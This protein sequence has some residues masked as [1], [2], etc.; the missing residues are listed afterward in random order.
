MS[1]LA[2]SL[3]G[4]V[5]GGKKFY[6]QLLQMQDVLFTATLNPEA[7]LKDKAACARAWE[8][9]EERKRIMRGKPLPGSHRPELPRK[10]KRAANV[11]PIARVNDAVDKPAA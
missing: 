6:R 9:L 1:A 11:T 2:P 7:D 3:I 4:K 5:E 8:Q 10:A